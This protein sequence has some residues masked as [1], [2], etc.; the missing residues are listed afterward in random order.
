MIAEGGGAIVMA[1][2]KTAACRAS[3]WGVI[4]SA[5]SA[6]LEVAR[7]N[8][9]LNAIAPGSVMT[10][11]LTGMFD[12]E[13]SAKDNGPA[14]DPYGPRIS[15]PPEIAQLVLFLSSDAASFIT[16]DKQS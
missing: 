5:N 4:G 6:A 16:G 10:P 2:A 15:D 14:D 1:F 13:Q 9:R 12:S 7:K 3:K 11:L 8:I